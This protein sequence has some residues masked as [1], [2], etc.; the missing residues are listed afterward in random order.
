M[1]ANLSSGVLHLFLS[2]HSCIRRLLLGTTKKPHRCRKDG[3]SLTRPISR[4]VLVDL[5]F[6][7]KWHFP[8]DSSKFLTP[9]AARGHQGWS[10]AIPPFILF[11]SYHGVVTTDDATVGSIIFLSLLFPGIVCSLPRGTFWWQKQIITFWPI[12]NLF[13]AWL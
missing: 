3:R 1:S 9:V 6:S 4:E 12:W 5:L 11:L 8:R 2:L 7:Q 13:H 10:L